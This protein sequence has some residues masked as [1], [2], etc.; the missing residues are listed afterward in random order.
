MPDGFQSM[1]QQAITQMKAMQSKAAPASEPPKKDVPL[2][3]KEE[4][5]NTQ[6]PKGAAASPVSALPPVPAPKPGAHL[7]GLLSRFLHMENDTAL[8]LPLLLLLGRE[9]ADDALLLALLY[10]MG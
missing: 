6:P 10:L 3:P 9:G 7:N 4:Q 1:Q 8:L 5:K 2:P